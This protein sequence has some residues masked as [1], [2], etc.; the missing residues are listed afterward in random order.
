MVKTA[1]EYMREFF[2]VASVLV[3][4][5][6]FGISVKAENN[7]AFWLL[8]GL[9][10]FAIIHAMTFAADKA[11]AEAKSEFARLLLNSLLSGQDTNI[12]VTVETRE[13]K[14]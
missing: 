13:V 8:L 3:L 5:G 2:H 1:F 4:G 14:P 7:F 10:V 11:R 12:N 6:M 9:F